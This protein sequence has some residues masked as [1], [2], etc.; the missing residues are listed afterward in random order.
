MPIYEYTCHDCGKIFDAMQKFSDVPLTECRCGKAGKCTKNLTAAGFALKGS[1][2][3]ATDFKGGASAKPADAAKD[4][5]K[6]GAK[7]DTAAGSPAPAASS[8]SASAPAATTPA[9]APG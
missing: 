4:T 7:A 1:G 3:Y 6:D 5:A 8:A 9:A 2:W